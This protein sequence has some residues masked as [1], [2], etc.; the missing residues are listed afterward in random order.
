MANPQQEKLLRGSNAYSADTQPKSL[1]PKRTLYAKLVT[2][3]WL[4]ELLAVAVGIACIVALCAVLKKYDNQPANRFNSLFGVN[5]T[6]NTL[7]S[8]LSTLGRAALLLAVAECISQ[9]KWKWYR[10]NDRPLADLDVFDQASR[11]AWGGFLLLWKINVRY[12]M[13]AFKRLTL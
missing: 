6:L 5:I 13:P 8:I 10:S 12:V 7:I 3:W 4:V 9:L 11:G 2:D 1:P